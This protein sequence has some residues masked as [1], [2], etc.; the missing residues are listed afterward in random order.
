MRTRRS[1]IRIAAAAFAA[2]ALAGCQDIFNA[3]LDNAA[4]TGV[5]ASDGEYPNT[6]DVSWNAPS[7]SGDKWKDYTISEYRVSWDGPDS[8]SHNTP[9]T[10]Y[11]IYVDDSN[12]AKKYTVTVETRLSPSASGGSASDDGFALEAE[13]MTW[14]DGGRSYPV[15]GSEAWYLTM[16]QKGFAYAFDFAS[17]QGSVEFYPYKTLDLVHTLESIAPNRSWTCDESGTGYKFFVRVKPSS[18][19][20]SFKASYD[21]NP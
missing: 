11:S 1:P 16:L 7:L 6:I 18:P 3:M 4:P 19:D 2:L 14:P 17:G 8:G 13:P 21:P 20:S 12:R 5:S 15:S 9:N 10:S